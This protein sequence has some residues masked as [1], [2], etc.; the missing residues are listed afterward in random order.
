MRIRP[1]TRALALA[2]VVA[3]LVSAWM[4]TTQQRA[5]P[6]IDPDHAATVQRTLGRV[7]AATDVPDIASETLTTV[8]RPIA[9]RSEPLWAL[10]GLAAALAALCLLRRL[11][12]SPALAAPR[13]VLPGTGARR[14]PPAGSFA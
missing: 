9:P 1:A 3:A 11:R 4:V 2:A 10:P 14:A 12:T 13:V 7:A 6:R 8:S 5:V